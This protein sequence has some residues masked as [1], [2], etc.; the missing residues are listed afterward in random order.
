MEIERDREEWWSGQ[1][2][3]CRCS[4]EKDSL[5]EPLHLG[6]GRFNQELDSSMPWFLSCR[7]PLQKWYKTY[8]HAMCI[9]IYIIVCTYHIDFFLRVTIWNWDLEL[10]CTCILHCSYACILPTCLCVSLGIDLGTRLSW[11]WSQLSVHLNSLVFVPILR[12]RW[13]G[14]QPSPSSNMRANKK[15]LWR[16][17]LQ[18]K[19]TN[20]HWKLLYQEKLESERTR[21]HYESKS[22]LASKSYTI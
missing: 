14:M 10:L 19:P 21:N 18:L 7:V 16:D 8:Q 13:A 3:R 4:N 1:C 17:E 15:W 2:S 6:F 20:T 12:L 22:I 11:L 9:Y 5:Q